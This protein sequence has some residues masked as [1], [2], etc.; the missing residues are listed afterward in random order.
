MRGEY[1]TFSLLGMDQIS[2]ALPTVDLR[3]MGKEFKKN[4]VSSPL[5]KEELPLVCGGS[6]IQLI[7]GI[8]QSL[9][10]PSRILVL[11]SGLQVWRSQ[12]KDVFGSTLIF[13]G[14]HASVRRAYSMLNMTSEE[15]T[16]SLL[17][18]KQYNLYRQHLVVEALDMDL[19]LEQEVPED[20]SNPLYYTSA[21]DWDRGSIPRVRP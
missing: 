18:T 12:L 6:E 15:D 7:I 11:D 21:R 8:R 13:A 14:P 20:R 9:L 10:F 1:H 4:Q 2:E 5:S 17:F 3:D 16:L 19:E